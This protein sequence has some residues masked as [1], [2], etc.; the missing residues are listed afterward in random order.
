MNKVVLGLDVGTSG[1]RACIVKK[2]TAFDQ[3]DDVIL[4]SEYLAMTMPVESTNGLGF[5]EVS[6]NPAVWLHT[7]DE[8][9]KKLTQRFDLSQVDQMVADATSSTVLLTDTMGRPLT[10]ALMYNDSRSSKE[11]IHIDQCIREFGGFSGASGASSSLAKT[12]YLASNLK[13]HRRYVGP[14]EEPIHVICHQI[15]LVNHFFCGILNVTD[16][17][18]ALKLGYDSVNQQWP[19]WVLERLKSQ[20][21]TAPL[22]V[23]PGSFIGK[24]RSNIARQYG[25]KTELKI[26]AG[27][28]DS[29]AGFLASGAHETGDAVSSL[30]SSLAIKWLSRTPVFN[31][32]LGVYSHK[33]GNRWLVGG[34]SNTGGKVVLHYY[35][36]P[37]LSLIDRLMTR[38][39]IKTVIS[40]GDLYYPLIAQGERFP[41]ADPK[42]KPVLPSFPNCSLA[43]NEHDK[44][45]LNAH[46]LFFRRLTLGLTQ[47][48]VHAY[49][50]L[51]K[52]GDQAIK[53]IFTV[54]G[55]LKNQTWM[56]FRDDM[57]PAPLVSA[58]HR[59]ASYGV[60][61]LIKE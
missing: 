54:G 53:R 19:K 25:F 43:S 13:K 1:I 40:E 28:T 21:L 58:K 50:T 35:S 5:K 51:Q 4:A 38:H 26:M 29:I 10:D 30:G 57:L 56:Q 27:T 36:K 47:V 11:A 39:Q 41:V 6:Q 2:K 17:N 7:L 45:C 23:E 22:V 46:I 14:V 48:E 32:E 12:L 9:L 18:N 33:L 20:R 3:V 49:E 8:L 42:K 59:D 16:E 15:D 31:S 24:I 34:A 61:K 37:E 44:S 60:T 55:G 52:M